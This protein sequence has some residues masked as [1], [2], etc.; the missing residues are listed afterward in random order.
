MLRSHRLAV[1]TVTAVLLTLSL[2]APAQAAAPRPIEVAS[3]T[4]GVGGVSAA[5]LAMQSEEYDPDHFDTSNLEAVSSDESSDTFDIGDGILLTEISPEPVNYQ[6]ADGAWVDISTQAVSSGNGKFEIKDNPLHPQFANSADDSGVLKVSNDG[7]SL[8]FTFLDA[9]SGAYARRLTPAEGDTY[10][11]VRYDGAAGDAD[12]SYQVGNASVKETIE[13]DEVPAV[14]S[15]SWAWQIAAPGLTLSKDDDGNLRFLKPDGSAQFV[16]PAPLMWDSSGLEG[17]REAAL[18]PVGTTITT[19]GEGKW[20]VSLVADHDW[21]ASTDRVYPVYIDPTTTLGDS[22]MTAYKSDGATRTDHVQVGNS[23]DSNTDK[24]WRTRIR[25]DYS[26]VYGKQ[27]LGSRLYATYVGGT[28]TER[29]GSVYTTDGSGYSGVGTKMANLTIDT[30]GSTSSTS[31]TFPQTVSDWVRSGSLHTFMIRGA[32]SA[33]AYTYKSLDTTLKITYKAFPSA[34]T[35]GLAIGG[36]TTNIQPRM[37]FSITDIA[38]EAPEARVLIFPS[39]VTT[40]DPLYAGPWISDRKYEVPEGVLLPETTYFW[41]VE[42]KDEYD[43]IYGTSTVRRSPVATFVTDDDPAGSV[44]EPTVGPLFDINGDV[45]AP[46]APVVGGLIEGSSILPQVVDTEVWLDSPGATAPIATCSEQGVIAPEYS[47]CTVQPELESNT[48]YKVRVRSSSLHTAGEWSVWHSFNTLP[49]VEEVDELP[50]SSTL[51]GAQVAHGVAYGVDGETAPA[52]TKLYMMVLPSTATVASLDLGETVSA[53]VVGM[54]TVGTAGEYG[55]RL[56]DYGSVADVADA[57]GAANVNIVGLVDGVDEISYSATIFLGEDTDGSYPNATMSNDGVPAVDPLHSSVALRPVVVGSAPGDVEGV[58]E[59]IPAG[60]V[61][62][63]EYRPYVT[64]DVELN[65]PIE[66]SPVGASFAPTPSV[67]GS[68]MVAGAKTYHPEQI[69]CTVTKKKSWKASTIVGAVWDQAGVTKSFDYRNGARSTLGVA[70]S[71]TGTK[72]SFKASGSASYE[73]TTNQGSNVPWDG[74]ATTGNYGFATNFGMTKVRTTC[75]T[76]ETNLIDDIGWH[77]LSDKYSVYSTG[78]TGGSAFRWPGNAPSLTKS[79]CDHYLKGT[80]SI[81]ME[82]GSADT[83]A[84]GVD[85]SSV[86]GID[87]SARTNY[88]SSSTLGIVPGT[89]GKWLCTTKGGIGLGGSLVVKKDS[90]YSY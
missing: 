87:L 9:E 83:F 44:G 74:K 16:V 17:V 21:L 20:K 57:G 11:E 72:G 14:D 41:L 67:T 45:A 77:Q 46:V 71:L 88:S 60:S 43:L 7:F 82:S 84:A 35:G 86:I 10:S 32:E 29:T 69:L 39:A 3:E 36:A 75:G 34:T 28:T 76:Y 26:N 47:S 55:F 61:F 68:E 13:L 70:T 90:T 23:R 24:Y 4:D 73:K 25:Y 30:E 8:A 66:L 53:P 27:V 64:D 40:G 58:A 1:T 6:R 85:V 18:R 63:S 50:D 37:E 80:R 33:G 5:Q 79:K 48:A 54:S 52:G 38:A 12:L 31:V 78:F 59:E 15:S 2:V 51:T 89:S 42:V 49:A 65:S 62:D 22:S 81:E 56:F 19:L